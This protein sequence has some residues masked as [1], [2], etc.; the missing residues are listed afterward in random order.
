MP[1]LCAKPLMFAIRGSLMRSLLAAI[2]IPLLVLACGRPQLPESGAG[3]FIWGSFYDTDVLF[4][5]FFPTDHTLMA[6]FMAQYELSFEAPVVAGGAR[7]SLLSAGTEAICVNTAAPCRDQNLAAGLFLRLGTSKFTYM[8]PRP[9][10]YMEGLQSAGRAPVPGNSLWRQLFL[11][12]RGNMMEVWL[13]GDHLCRAGFPPAE[14]DAPIGA[15]APVGPLRL[16]QRSTDPNETMPQFYGLID[17]VALFDHA[18]GAAEIS[19]W[20]TGTEGPGAGDSGVTAWIDFNQAATDARIHPASTLTGSAQVVRV[21][22]N[23]DSAADSALLPI[24]SGTAPIEIPFAGG[25]TWEVIQQF[26]VRGTHAGS[27]AFSWDFVNVPDSHPRGTP[28]GFGVESDEIGFLA[29]ASGQVVAIDVSHPLP[30]W[31]CPGDIEYGREDCA[32]NV[33]DVQQ[34]PQQILQYLHQ[35]RATTNLVVGDPVTR[36][37]RLGIVSNV[38]GGTP[39][40]HFAVV[41]RADQFGVTRPS[42]FVNYCV[43]TDFGMT[44]ALVPIGMPTNGQWVR[45]PTESGACAA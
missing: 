44:W 41:D 30:G 4:E 27:A 19:A 33:L 21:S 29:G 16:G 36:G 8:I 22:A 38:G 39:H 37:Q 25:E 35:R 6:R 31:L 14:C 43:S 40:L 24:L 7:A 15:V 10:P 13:D 2:C 18:L 45:R 11:V 5:S 1:P 34:Q 3:Q 9:A 42:Y 20:S 12:R 28:R 17:D 23:H 26:A 32:P